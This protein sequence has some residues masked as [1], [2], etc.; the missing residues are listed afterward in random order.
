M[1][2]IVIGGSLGGLFAANLVARAGWEVEVF[3]HSGE[4]LAGRGAGIVP[5][6]EQFQALE[7]IG[8]PIDDSFGV[9]IPLRVTF[10][11]AGNLVASLPL[12]QIFTTW[13]RLYQLLRGALPRAHYHLGHSLENLSQDAGGVT[14]RFANGASARGDLLIGAD[15]IRS[16]VRA[17]LAPD[18]KPVYAGYV[19]WRGLADENDLSPS[20][21]RDLIPRLAFC[22]PPREMILGYPVA[23]FTNSVRPGSRCYNFVW[24]RPAE[25]ARELP[26]LCTDT[27][28]SRHDMS[29]PPPL[30]RPEILAEMRRAAEELLAPQ[31]A[32]AVHRARQPFFQAIFDV[33]SEKMSFGRVALLGDAAFVAR[34]HVGMGVTKAAGDAMALADALRAS[35]NDVPAAL[36]RYDA[37]RRPFGAA[38]VAH[39]REL[40]AWLQGVATPEAQ[41]HHTPQAVMSEIAVTPEFP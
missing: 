4:E 11:R 35:G 22:L 25:E 21:H 26:R 27:A 9:D 10:D 6:P 5:H 14:A 28:G 39:G 3:E 30:L 13:G 37:E 36:A 2:A 16:T 18:A 23:G 12:K 20:A 24:Y 17:R 41:R 31:F 32:E 40:G 15:G 33:E 29:I 7:R 8:V 1:R 19:A 38:V 34:P